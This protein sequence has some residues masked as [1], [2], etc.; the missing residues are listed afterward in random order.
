MGRIDPLVRTVNLDQLQRVS[1]NTDRELDADW[2]VDV[3]KSAKRKSNQSSNQ[4]H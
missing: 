2:N 3:T 4:E 1:M